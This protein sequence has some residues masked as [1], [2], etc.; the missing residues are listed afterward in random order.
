MKS[1]DVLRELTTQPPSRLDALP[2]DHGI[3][4][5]HDHEGQIRYFGITKNDARGFYGRINNR[6]SSGSEERSHK[7]S[8]A[9]NT[10]RMWRKKKDNSPDAVTAKQLRTAFIRRH[11]RA[12]FVVVPPSQASDLPRL[13][14][15]V[16]ALAPTTMMSWGSK[17]AF[18]PVDEP[19]VLVDA[20]LVDLG[21]TPMQRTA[22]ER[23]ATMHVAL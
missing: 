9:Y 3:Y 23:Q 7:F 5:L 12:T 14:R 15:E 18:V 8:H 11:C 10:G 13:E 16:Q 19:K 20:L 21:F 22:V 1:T 17:R 2:R 6:H 4:A